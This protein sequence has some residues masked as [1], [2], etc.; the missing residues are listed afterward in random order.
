MKDQ[1]D[2]EFISWDH[3][4]PYSELPENIHEYWR[5]YILDL[6]LP[7][8]M[9]ES[10][11]KQFNKSDMIWIDHHISGI[12]AFGEKFTDCEGIRDI[13]SAACVL[14][15][16][17]FYG[18]EKIPYAVDYIGQRDIWQ[19]EDED[20]VLSFFEYISLMDMNPDSD[21]WGHFFT[22]P[23]VSVVIDEGRKYRN[24]RM[25]I[26]AEVVESIGYES[27]IDGHKCLKVNFSNFNSISDMGHYIVHKLNYPVAWIYYIKQADTGD[28]IVS[29]NLRSKNVDV[30]KIASE[31]GG[32]GHV[33]ASG[34]TQYIDKELMFT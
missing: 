16:R 14:T 18:M 4:D 15:W 22:N 10:L 19:M 20:L 27:E 2:V 3:T 26:I 11:M 13:R 24:A 33:Q 21:N 8:I 29:N 23:D 32:G 17:W 25:K 31:R 7:G 1:A 6:T 34:W 12:R 5:V 28:F 30:S 9:M